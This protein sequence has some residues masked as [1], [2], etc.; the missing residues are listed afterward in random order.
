MHFE[1]ILV[2]RKKMLFAI[3][4]PINGCSSQEPLALRHCGWQSSFR[5]MKQKQQWR[6][7]G[8]NFFVAMLF[9]SLNAR[10]LPAPASSPPLGRVSFRISKCKIFVEPIRFLCS[11]SM[12]VQRAF[13]RLFPRSRFSTKNEEKNKWRKLRQTTP[14][15]YLPDLFA[16][17]V[18]PKCS[19]EEKEDFFFFLRSSEN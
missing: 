9:F 19:T 4:V 3:T 17:F 10:M 13:K 7:Q 5:Q 14:K 6:P 12:R 11:F 1:H 2:W 15:E 18:A 16:A 8:K